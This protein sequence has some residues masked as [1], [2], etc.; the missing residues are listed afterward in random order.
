M[1][2]QGNGEGAAGSKAAAG[3]GDM[4]AV[5][6]DERLCD[7]QSDAGAAM[8]A[9]AGGVRPVEAFEYMGQVVDGDTFAGIADG[10]HELFRIEARGDFDLTI[11]RSVAQGVV[12]KVG[13]HLRKSLRICP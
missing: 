9:V 5:G 4:T 3:N 12:Q 1:D 7:G 10:D 13:E 11:R 2:W 6:F 8:I